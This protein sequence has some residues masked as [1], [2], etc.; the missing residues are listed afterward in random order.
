VSRQSGSGVRLVKE[1]HRL[2]QQPQGTKLRA[3]GAQINFQN[4]PVLSGGEIEGV[5]QWMHRYERIWRYNRWGDDELRDHEEL[6]LTGAAMKWLTYKD[7]T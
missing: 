6:S 5:E 2:Q 3:K 7:G 1:L 4:P